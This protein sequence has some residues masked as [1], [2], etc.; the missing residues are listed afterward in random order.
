MNKI[1]KSEDTTKNTPAQIA[2]HFIELYIEEDRPIN[3]TVI[4]GYV[5][6]ASV[7]LGIITIDDIVNQ[8]YP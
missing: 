6:N 2:K 4:R 5:M 3:L 8:M 1:Q 7:K